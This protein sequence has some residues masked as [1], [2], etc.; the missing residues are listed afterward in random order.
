M[1]HTTLPSMSLG[2]IFEPRP[3]LLHCI[4]DLLQVHNSRVRLRQRLVDEDNVCSRGLLKFFLSI[5]RFRLLRGWRFCDPFW[6]VRIFLRAHLGQ[7][8]NHSSFSMNL[9]RW[10]DSGALLHRCGCLGL[11]RRLHKSILLSTIFGLV[12]LYTAFSAG[13]L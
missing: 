12:F 9:D 8:L 7:C 4:V 11:S 3:V 5:L 2:P 13:K 1:P 6:L 10:R